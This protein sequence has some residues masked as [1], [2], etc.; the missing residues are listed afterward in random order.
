MIDSRD[1]EPWSYGE[2]AEAVAGNYIRLRYKLLPTLYSSFK[3]SSVTG[4]AVLKPYFWE[5]AFLEFEVAFQHQFFWCDNLLVIPAASEQAAVWADLPEG[6]W[7][8]LFTGEKLKGEQSLWLSSPLD[9]LPVLVKEGTILVTR[10]PGTHSLD[11]LITD[12]QIHLFYGS[13]K[14]SFYFYDDDGLSENSTEEEMVEAEINFDFD[15]M[16]IKINPI[17]GKKEI[18]ITTFHLWHFPEGAQIH[19]RDTLYSSVNDKWSWLD[20]LP[21]FDPFEDKGKTYFDN[22]QTITL[23]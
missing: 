13:G 17:S 9:A 7:Y 19:F 2:L 22:C 12:F 1:N 11:P 10:Q 21:N 15:L 18:Q 5:K 23:I 14:S 8:N 20:K 16:A 6:N 4:E 3:K